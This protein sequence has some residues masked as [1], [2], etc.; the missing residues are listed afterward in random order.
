MIE[1]S[2]ALQIS[3]E[4]ERSESERSESRREVIRNNYLLDG[5]VLLIR[6]P[7]RPQTSALVALFQI[8]L[9]Y[10]LLPGA[11]IEILGKELFDPRGVQT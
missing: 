7:L 3:A 9:T 10:L 1:L 11:C 6:P 8:S 4:S 2:R 5:R